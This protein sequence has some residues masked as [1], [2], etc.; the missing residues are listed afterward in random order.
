MLVDSFQYANIHKDCSSLFP[1]LLWVTSIN[2]TFSFENR[3]QE[4]QAG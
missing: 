4:K 3:K 1:K 2:Q